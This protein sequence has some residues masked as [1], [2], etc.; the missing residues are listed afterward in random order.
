MSNT[1]PDVASPAVRPYC[2]WYPDI[3]TEDTYREMVRCYPDM[4][5]HAG[6]ASAVAGYKT[7]YDELN[8]L[9]DVSIA[10]EARDNGHTAIFDSI[11]SQPVRYTVMDDYTR[12]VILQNP[13]S[14]ACLN[15]DTAVRS[16]LRRQWSGAG[17]DDASKY[18]SVNSY[19]FHWFNIQEDFNVD[20]FHWPPPGSSALQDDE[21]NLLHQ[22]LPRDLPPINKDILILMAA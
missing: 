20:T 7:L 14:G 11:A 10:E 18:F 19:P 17:D 9:P 1:V 3:A 13:R 2:V 5:Y 12:S 16:S 15:G 21:V 4:R 22:P 8:L 6:R